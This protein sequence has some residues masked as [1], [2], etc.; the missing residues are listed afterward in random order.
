MLSITSPSV[1][2]LR[3]GIVA[4]VVCGI[5]LVFIGL[6]LYPTTIS[7]AGILAPLAPILI[8]IVYATLG[9]SQARVT[10]P[11]TLRIG[12]RIGLIIGLWFIASSIFEYIVVLNV[13]A[14]QTTGLVTYAAVALLFLSAGFIGVRQDGHLRSG[15]VS[16]LWSAVVGGL[17]W[18]LITFALLYLFKGS[19]HETNV[20]DLEMLGD[21]QR[22][23]MSDY[24]AFVMSDYF[25]AGF[26]HMILLPLASVIFGT[27]GA[28]LSKLWDAL[29]RHASRS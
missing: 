17:L 1:T 5:I 26:Y 28:G 18:F 15:I 19:A 6:L 27:L 22:S 4:V 29:F 12:V 24:S 25:G 11:S 3:F 21:F 8:L 14:N 16:A 10:P 7:A 23:G 9:L 20:Q 13:S 2:R